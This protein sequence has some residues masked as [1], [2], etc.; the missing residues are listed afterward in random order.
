MRN[1]KFSRKYLGFAAG[2]VIEPSLALSPGE[3]YRLTRD[4]TLVEVDAPLPEKKAT[5]V[6]EPAPA[7][8]VTTTEADSTVVDV[9]PKRK[10]GRPR[11][12]ETTISL[13]QEQSE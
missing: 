1:M 3:I 7:E 10:R 9:A 12:P 4:G 11:K 6:V 2:Q 13:E 5:P 8:P